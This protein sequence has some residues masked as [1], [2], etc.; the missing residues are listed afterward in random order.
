VN[1][2]A[3]RGEYGFG[4]DECG[5]LAWWRACHG[6]GRNKGSFTPGRGYTSYHKK[7]IP[8]CGTRYHHGCPTGSLIPQDDGTR[9]SR[10]PDPDW[11][12]VWKY[13][14]T[15]RGVSRWKWACCL[16]GGLLDS[17]KH[18]RMLAEVN[19][20]ENEQQQETHD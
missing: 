4:T 14:Q 1:K 11:S 7:E 8:V 12:A 17:V 19:W 13:V 3:K 20:K 15:Q 18:W 2:P 9:L 5:P 10:Q 6:P 16:I